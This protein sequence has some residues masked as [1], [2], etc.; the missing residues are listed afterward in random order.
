MTLFWPVIVYRAIRGSNGIV[1]CS[2][3]MIEWIFGE[4]FGLIA[5]RSFGEEKSFEPL[6]TM[7]RCERRR[8]R[9][10]EFRA[11]VENCIFE[12]FE[13]LTMS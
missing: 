3:W 13:V 4:K 1:D 6:F 10:G 9:S 7:V 12:G 11:R 8:R 2:A 5:R